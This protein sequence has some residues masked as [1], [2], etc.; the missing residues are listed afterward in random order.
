M[1]TYQNE[2]N[3]LNYRWITAL[4][5]THSVYIIIIIIFSTRKINY[6]LSLME[7]RGDQNNHYWR[8]KGKPDLLVLFKCISCICIQQTAASS[9]VQW[10]TTDLLTSYFCPSLLLPHIESLTWTQWQVGTSKVSGTF[11]SEPC[12]ALPLKAT[13][14]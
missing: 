12:F 11:S 7:L 3:H 8:S 9:Q 13:R 14:D 4:Q 6:F 10:F 1:I 5:N 2:H